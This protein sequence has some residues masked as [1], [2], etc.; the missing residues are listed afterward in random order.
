MFNKKILFLLSTSL[1]LILACS[2]DIN[3]AVPTE[4]PVGNA[5]AT[6]V[7]ATLQANAAIP[8][9]ISAPTQPPPPPAVFTP[10]VVLSPTPSVPIA[11]VSVDTNCRT[12]PGQD[13]EIIGALTV[14]EKA[15]IV[16]KRTSHEYWVIK[17]PDRNGECWLW[18]YYA[19]VAGDTSSLREYDIPEPPLPSPPN[20]PSNLAAAVVCVAGP[21]PNFMATINLI[22]TDNSDDETR[23][24]FYVNGILGGAFL[25]DQTQEN[26]NLPVTGG[27][28]AIIGLSAFNDIGESDIQTIQVECP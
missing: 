7:A 22:W 2:I 6:S 4:V 3:T 20:A 25:A 1:I 18:G 24:N 8:N 21:P 11:S 5:V 27:A 14:G 26:F 16:G 28:P 17:N 12:G 23:F 10:T 19:M 15:E 13:Y 9:P